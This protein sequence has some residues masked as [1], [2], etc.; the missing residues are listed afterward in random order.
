MRR[1]SIRNSRSRSIRT[2]RRRARAP[3]PCSA[4]RRRRPASA[5]GRLAAAAPPVMVALHI[6]SMTHGIASLFLGPSG[7]GQLPMAPGELLEAG[8]LVYLQSLDL[9]AAAR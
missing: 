6:L 1:C 4:G 2:W 9:G 3:W 8:L 7:A 5:A